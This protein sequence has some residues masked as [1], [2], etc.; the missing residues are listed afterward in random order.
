MSAPVENYR[1]DI[2]PDCGHALM[3]ESTCADY[4]EETIWEYM[5]CYHCG[6]SRDIL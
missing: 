5:T 1:D 2:C 4:D 3:Y 6:Y